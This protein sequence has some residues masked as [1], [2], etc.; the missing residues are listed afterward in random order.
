MDENKICIA[1]Y[2][3]LYFVKFPKSKK[4]CLRLRVECLTAI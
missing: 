3:M 2:W 4:T 1:A